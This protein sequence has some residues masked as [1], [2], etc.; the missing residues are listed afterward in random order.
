MT[1]APGAY[2]GGVM[3]PLER[4]PVLHELDG[5]LATATWAVGSSCWW[6]RLG[7]EGEQPFTHYTAD[8]HA[9]VVGVSLTGLRR[10]S[11]RVCGGGPGAG[12]VLDGVPGL[13]SGGV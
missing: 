11:G 1:G 8:D 4:A 5:V 6:A 9:A 7:L 3:D 10:G 13:P 2:V 12:G